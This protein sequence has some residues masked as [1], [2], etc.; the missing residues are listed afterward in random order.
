MPLQDVPDRDDRVVGAAS[1]LTPTFPTAADPPAVRT[2]SS[3]LRAQ[4]GRSGASDDRN[5]SLMLVLFFSFSMIQI[6]MKGCAPGH[7]GGLGDELVPAAASAALQVQAAGNG[8]RRIL[9][10]LLQQR[11]VQAG[12]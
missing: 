11:K 8:L 6:W 1:W 7:E 5:S 4:P 12:V 2:S 3:V 10:Q 9:W